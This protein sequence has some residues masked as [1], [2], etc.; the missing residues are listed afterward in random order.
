MLTFSSALRRNHQKENA[1][2][3]ILWTWVNNFKA[4]KD[5]IE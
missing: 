4:A 1:S 3:T 2:N 5:W